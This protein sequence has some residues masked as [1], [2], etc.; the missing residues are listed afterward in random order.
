MI[1]LKGL[2]VIFSLPLRLLWVIIRYPFDGGA[3]GKYKN[4]LSKAL[5]LAICRFAISLSVQDSSVLALINTNFVINK[6][7]KTFYPSLT[8]L[9]NYG[10]RYDKQSIWLVEA[11]DRSS[12]DPI[13]I[14]CHGGGYFLETQPQ[15]IE[16]LLSMYHLLDEEKRK[17]ASILVLEY[18]LACHG[19]LIGTQVYELAATYNKLASEGNGNFVLMGDSCGGNLVIVFLQYLQYQ[20]QDLK[21][22]WPRSAVLICPWV[23]IVPDVNQLTP[24]HS[25]YDNEQYDMVQSN[26]MLDQK[27]QLALFGNTSYAD[28]FI[29]PGNV[30]YKYSDWSAIP[31]LHSRGYS[32]LVITGEHEVFRDDTLEWAKYA[33]NSPLEPSKQDS[34]G[35]FNHQ[36]HEFKTS[37]ADGAYI[38]V[39]IEPWGI[40]ESVIFFEHDAIDKLKKEPHLQLKDLD[41]V[42]YFGIV[43]ITEFLNKIFSSE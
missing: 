14:F 4:S 6:I 42:E 34:G 20:Q 33:L 8:Q 21:L 43:K 37:G 13:I 35:V 2:F 38:D 39:V 31:T 25:Y 41:T 19:R 23:K 18:G 22:P 15:Q 28:L 17:K 32:T 7:V 11:K 10:K 40:H 12:S 5:K 16:S 29:S 26:F 9:N 24:G 30:E 27:R 1:S 3:K 36:I